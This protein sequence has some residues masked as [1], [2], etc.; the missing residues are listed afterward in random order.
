MAELDF[1]AIQSRDIER[2][3]RNE[4]DQLIH[5]QGEVAN[6]LELAYMK[7]GDHP[8]LAKRVR[9]ASV[10]ARSRHQ[11]TS[12]MMKSYAV[13]SKNIIKT[14]V[15]LLKMAAKFKNEPLMKKA[16][17]QIEENAV[18]MKEETKKLQTGYKA[19]QQQVSDDYSEAFTIKKQV[20]DTHSKLEVE[21]HSARKQADLAEAAAKDSAVIVETCKMDVDKSSEKR[22]EAY[23]LK[24][25]IGEKMVVDIEKEEWTPAAAVLTGAALGTPVSLVAG[26][27]Y[28]A[29][30]LIYNFMSNKK[31]KES[32]DD[33]A[34]F[35]AFEKSYI[36]ASD[37]VDRERERLEKHR[38]ETIDRKKEAID[39]VRKMREMCSQH[40]SAGD[41]QCLVVV[42]ENLGKV[43]AILT[44]IIEFWSSMAAV[45][46]DI[47]ENGKTLPRILI[48][49]DES[50][51]EEAPEEM[52][53]ELN[54]MV[55]NCILDVEKGWNLVGGICY[56]Y[57]RDNDIRLL[58]DYE[59]L[60]RP[61]DQMAQ[62][63][64]RTRES[65]LLMLMEQ[66]VEKAY[67]TE[68]ARE[69]A[70]EEDMCI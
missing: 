12:F 65:K 66:E 14:I 41:P 36:N 59:F 19:I 31:N 47:I 10:N 5:S 54:G 37:E 69:E 24:S 58:R 23:R 26:A 29:G 20:E 3:R 67:A 7:L 25:K 57:I 15:P 53:A 45:A 32:K 6:C 34:K 64:R 50:F 51:I 44:R 40:V 33:L 52:K 16:F 39:N 21:M 35:K 61:I 68:A 11:D 28:A 22:D 55:Q 13:T 48:G 30:K 63:D 46:Q 38:M 2:V 18:A 60:S 17:K 56:V 1:P 49:L 70:E 27:A 4:L 43:D 42:Q 9:Q 62:A 8:D